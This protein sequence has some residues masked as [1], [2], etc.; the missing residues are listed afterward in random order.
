MRILLIL[1]AL[2]LSPAFC[3]AEDSHVLILT[4]SGA[5]AVH[6][7]GEV[8]R[9]ER[10][11]TLGAPPAPE[12][13]PPPAPE[14]ELVGKSKA[15]AEAA[16][17]PAGAQALAIV[18]QQAAEAV[19]S[20]VVGPLDG[21]EVVRK[22]SDAALALTGTRDRWSEFRDS[23]SLVITARINRGELTEPKQMAG[24]FAEA[25]RGLQASAAAAPEIDEA[26]AIRVAAI[27]LAS[28]EAINE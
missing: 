10:V 16:G 18:Y 21:V 26:T 14:P 4:K 17:D 11:I 3:G 7:D 9:Y 13:L 6:A 25:A 19:E 5:V 27:I 20:G 8:V 12:P 15:W 1:L 23:L 22:S 28:I 24:L 2:L